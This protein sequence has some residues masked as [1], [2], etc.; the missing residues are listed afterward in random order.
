MT[1][2]HKFSELEASM[3]KERQAR[4]DRVAAKLGDDMDVAQLRTARQLS[5]A[6]RGEIMQFEQP[7]IVKLGK[8]AAGKIVC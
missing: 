7:A 6:T 3:P 4:I 8:R 5:Q 2:R 1:G